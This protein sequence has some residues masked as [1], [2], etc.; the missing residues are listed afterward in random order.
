M[1]EAALRPDRLGR[2]ADKKSPGTV[3][4]VEGITPAL[5][6][7]R[8]NAEVARSTI[9]TGRAYSDLTEVECSFILADKHKT[10]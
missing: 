5:T 7:V 3:P 4:S 2:T 9:G 6:P 10:L 8:N 1:I